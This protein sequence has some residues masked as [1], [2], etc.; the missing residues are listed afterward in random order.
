MSSPRLRLQDFWLINFTFS[1]NLSL[2]PFHAFSILF[3]ACCLCRLYIA[4][5]WCSL[6]E[7]IARSSFPELGPKRQHKAK[8]HSDTSSELW[9]QKETTWSNMRKFGDPTITNFL[10]RL[11]GSLWQVKCWAYGP[12]MDQQQNAPWLHD[13]Q[14]TSMT[15]VA[16][17]EAATAATVFSPVQR[18]IPSRAQRYVNLREQLAFWNSPKS[19]KP[20]FTLLV[21]RLKVASLAYLWPQNSTTRLRDTERDINDITNWQFPVRKLLEHGLPVQRQ[22]KMQDST[23]SSISLAKKLLE[24]NG[25]N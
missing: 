12:S 24:L 15:L 21:A 5:L 17:V 22:C 1:P 7:T 25:R 2:V 11:G 16:S 8:T 19:A 18:G 13:H 3:Y 20:W 10:D 4:V 9:A 6:T 14:W 23:E